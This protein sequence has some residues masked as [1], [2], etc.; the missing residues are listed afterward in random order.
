[1]LSSYMRIWDPGLW[2]NHKAARFAAR[3]LNFRCIGESVAYAVSSV[4]TDPAQHLCQS[5]LARKQSRQCWVHVSEYK[6]RLTYSWQSHILYRQIIDVQVHLRSVFHSVG[7]WDTVQG[8]MA[9]LKLSLVGM[10][11]HMIEVQALLQSAIQSRMT[12]LALNHANINKLRLIVVVSFPPGCAPPVTNKP[13][14][15]MYPQSVVH[16]L[17]WFGSF[18]SSYP[19]LWISG[20]YA[21]R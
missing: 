16:S 5:H 1:M 3:W 20:C 2:I 9:N 13:L 6:I 17:F 10:S 12:L 11:C 8:F 14:I 7:C 19:W 4:V 15:S 18:S 21:H